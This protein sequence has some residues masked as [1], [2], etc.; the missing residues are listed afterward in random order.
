M[1]NW[2][3]NMLEMDKPL[4]HQGF[5]YKTVENFY[6]AMKIQSLTERD[7]ISKMGPY[8]AN[9]NWDPCKEPRCSIC[10]LAY[11]YA[12]LAYKTGKYPTKEQLEQAGMV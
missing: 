1:K 8:Q 11:D 4:K 3:S 9:G 12:D 6:Q 10:P 5:E 2:F 7:R